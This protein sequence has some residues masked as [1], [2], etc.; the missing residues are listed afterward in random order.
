MISDETRKEKDGRPPLFGIHHWWNRTP[1][2]LSRA[3]IL[4]ALLPEDFPIPEFNAL[5]G[6]NHRKGRAYNHDLT[7][8]QSTLLKEIYQEEWGVEKPLLL[9]PFS[10]G[11][12]IPF[13]SLRVGCD[14][15]SVDYSPLACLIQQATIQYPA[16]YSKKMWLDLEETINR[17]IKEAF[18]SLKDFYPQDNGQDVATYL[19]AWVV[20]CPECGF[21]NPLVSQ[22]WLAKRR[23]KR[24]YLDPQIHKDQ[25]KFSIKT[26]GQP[27]RGNISGGDAHCLKCNHTIPGDYIIRE[28]LQNEEEML[29]ATVKI[30]EKGKE[31]SLPSREDLKALEKA[32]DIGRDIDEY[33]HIQDLLPLD[34]IPDDIKGKHHAKPYL[35][36]WHKL[37][38]HRQKILFSTLIESIQEYSDSLNEENPYTQALTTYL[39]FMVG[40][41][42]NRNCRSTRYD[43]KHENIRG[44]VSLPGIPLLWDHTETNPF[45]K[46][47]GS[48][49]VIKNEILK[50]LEYSENRIL[51]SLNHFPGHTL[52]ILNQSILQSSTKSPLI[53]T[54]IPY[55][56]DVQYGEISDFFYVF[57]KSGLNHI[58][59]LPSESPKT[60]D[61]SISGIRSTE[62]FNHLF[63]ESFLKLHSLLEEDGLM[64]LYFS[65]KSLSSWD[66]LI[67]IIIKSGFRVTA[68][69]PIHTLQPRNPI[70]KDYASLES[71]LIVVARKTVPNEVNE[72]REVKSQIRNPENILKEVDLTSL[73]KNR[74]QELWDSGLKG[75]DLTIALMG[76]I[77]NI[78]S[79]NE[80]FVDELGNGIKK[81]DKETGNPDKRI[82]TD[83]RIETH[84][85][86]IHQMYPEI[87]LKGENIILNDMLNLSQHHII[88][89][90]LNR[91][92]KDY[93]E[94]DG[95]TRFY[96]FCR[97]SGLDG[98][99]R[100]TAN[101]ILK[102]MDMDLDT[103]IKAGFIKLIKKGRRR[104]LKILKFH[105]RL[106]INIEYQI[107][108]AHIALNLYEMVGARRVE[109]FIDK[110]PQAYN[111][112]SVLSRI[113]FDDAEQKLAEGIVNSRDISSESIRDLII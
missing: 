12:S 103:I 52:E 19:Y 18:N 48:L 67:N 27:P 86:G 25:I 53:V 46:S 77:L 98:M 22:W 90:F 13:E 91:F 20:K 75:T 8:I 7:K 36:Y 74:I 94:L 101:L 108:A 50:G 59:D 82:K 109:S 107:D 4:A 6:L 39:T 1:L 26:D 62:Y 110:Y 60:D 85:K 66:Y 61:L 33:I 55:E 37:L 47:S 83:K 45:V 51:K 24:I 72:N 71:S 32:K 73:L 78:L 80:N 87:N 84:D 42:I 2:T 63:Q 44:T 102:S 56:D 41:H 81:T 30:G 64:V 29:L 15:S 79:Q 16:R 38:N 104:G 97:L 49:E 10:G 65:H 23:Q 92:V 54:H 58:L 89:W 76:F 99:N 35:K 57:E 106:D 11:G 9:D 43:R 88:H 96:L 5:M 21:H 3:M 112:L 100:E 70:L 17:I 28:I 68:L 34:E 31:Y 14:V 105:E 113:E 95:P 111:V 40:K 69:W 93:E